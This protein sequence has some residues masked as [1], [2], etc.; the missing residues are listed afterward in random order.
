MKLAALLLYAAVPVALVA[1]S[2][3]P[4]H[5]CNRL[6][7]GY[8]LIEDERQRYLEVL[9][10]SN[11]ALFVVNFVNGGTYQVNEMAVTMLGYTREQLARLTI[12]ALQPASYPHLSAARIADAWNGKSLIYD[13]ALLRS[14]GCVVPV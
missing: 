3:G 12:F 8:T 7:A 13:I 6:R 9:E 4:A 10:A 11:D 1:I 14:N 5:A 2:A